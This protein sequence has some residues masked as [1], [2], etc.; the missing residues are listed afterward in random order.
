MK[1]FSANTVRDLAVVAREFI[2]T[3]QEPGIFLLRGAMGAGKT[4]FVKSII[5]A[6]DAGKALS[7]TFSLV[8]EYETSGG[9]RVFHL[10]LYRVKSIEEALDFG[11]DEYLDSRYYVFIEWPDVILPLL[12]EKTVDINIAD[13]N[14]VRKIIF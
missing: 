1:N 6:L 3:F 5:Q 2:R 8:N 11:V 7:P 14:G 13:E 10:D 9:K 4:T 12:K